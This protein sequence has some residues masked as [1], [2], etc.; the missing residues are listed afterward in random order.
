MAEPAADPDRFDAAVDAFRKRVPVD[1]EAW[2]LLT[3]QQRERAFTVSRVTEGRVLQSTLDAIDRA[4]AEGGTLQEF[5][6]S[7]AAD[8]IE[9]WGG[10]I[11]GRLELIFKNNVLSSYSEG[12]HAI[13][14]SPTVKQARP[15]KR[16]DDSETDRECEI[17]SE[18]GGVIL[19]ADDPWWPT[20]TPL[21]HHGCE[22]K[23]TPLSKEEAEEEG[24]DGKGPGVDA[25]EG[26]GAEPSQDGTNWDF[27]L[28]GM[29]PE[30]R[31]IVEEAL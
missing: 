17:C 1:R 21:M 3:T 25:D 15:Y 12:R 18:C 20:H 16:F 14:S 8:L 31:A 19:P 22:C 10:E 6:D 2:D 13:M 28:S 23:I 4:V 29:D 24:I 11:P 7:V 27:D 5:K 30:L 26:F 9:A